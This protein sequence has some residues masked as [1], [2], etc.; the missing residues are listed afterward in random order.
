MKQSD[1]HK[2]DIHN[3]KT[4]YEKLHEL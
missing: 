2:V 3:M 1:E 4:L